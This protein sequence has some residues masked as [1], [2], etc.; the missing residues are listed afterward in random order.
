MRD[1]LVIALA[2]A[3]SSACQRPAAQSAGAGPG[4]TEAKSASTADRPSAA[5]ATADGAAAEA[6]TLTGKAGPKAPEAVANLPLGYAFNPEVPQ[7]QKPQMR[8][9][10]TQNIS[11]L[12]M[13]FVRDD[14]KRFKVEHGDLMSGQAVVVPIGD[15]EAG[16]F[17]YQ[18]AM[19]GK[20]AGRPWSHDFT[21]ATLVRSSLKVGYDAQHLDL[22]KRTLQFTLSKP[23]AS[24]SLVIIGDDG[25]E[26]GRASAKY[27]GEAPGTWLPI[28]WK[29]KPGRVMKLLLRVKAKN[30]LATRVE[31]VPWSVA[32]DHDDLEFA[33]N[34][35]KIDSAEEP[36]LKASLG[37]IAKVIDRS[38]RFMALKLYI[39]GH[40]DTVGS[41]K[42]NRGLSQRR[43]RAIAEYMR[44]NGVAIPIEVAGFGEEVL[45]V[46]TPDKTDMRANRRVDYVLGPASGAPP[47]G[48]RYQGTG[49]RWRQLP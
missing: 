49:V 22:D 40:T 6:P 25:S 3:L 39:A 42:K 2:I 21:F 10:A 16:R 8:L 43:A 45:K 11:G 34:S 4:T 29:Q 12:R 47:F 9:Q 24:A 26:L 48:A 19:S 38:G 41:A 35:S 23:T 15:G 14:G 20:A 28:T 33:T 17:Q 37:K 31:L 7:G 44:A 30:G 1:C 32:I 46:K 18:G 27:R 5:S 36:K 13:E